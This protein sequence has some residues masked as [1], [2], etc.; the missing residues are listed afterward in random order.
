MSSSI[1][2]HCMVQNLINKLINIKQ[3]R[4]NVDIMLLLQIQND[5]E[6]KNGDVLYC[7]VFAIEYQ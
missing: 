1:G 7:I 5:G 6:D 4:Q 3:Q 2:V